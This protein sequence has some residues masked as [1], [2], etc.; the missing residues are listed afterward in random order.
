M[1]LNL[2][3]NLGK[4]FAVVCVF[5]L[6]SGVYML[7]K[8]TEEEKVLGQQM[9]MYPIGFTCTDDNG[10]EQVIKIDMKSQ[11]SIYRDIYQYSMVKALYHGDEKKP[12]GCELLITGNGKKT[13]VLLYTSED[14][15]VDLDNVRYEVS[16]DKDLVYKVVEKS[17]KKK[18]DNIR[19]RII[20]EL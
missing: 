7:L 6:I 17:V 2:I 5:F 12:F 3:K 10:G 18:K 8:P 15:P 11:L 19:F 4:I 14:G 13:T 16:T 1:L 9:K 20:E